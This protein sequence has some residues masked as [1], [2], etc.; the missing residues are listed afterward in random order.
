MFSSV[1]GMR[2]EGISSG[3]ASKVEPA[4]AVDGEEWLMVLT[5]YSYLLGSTS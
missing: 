5:Q 3:S 4:V 2:F 1:S